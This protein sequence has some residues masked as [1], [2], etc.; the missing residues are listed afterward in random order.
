MALSVQMPK[1]QAKRAPS[2]ILLFLSDDSGLL[3]FV[4]IWEGHHRS[5]KLGARGPIRIRQ[6]LSPSLEAEGFLEKNVSLGPSSSG[7]VAHWPLVIH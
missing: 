2:E 1:S 5:Y 4:D 6:G 3:L 7:A